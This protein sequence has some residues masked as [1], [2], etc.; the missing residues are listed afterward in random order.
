MGC[1]CLTNAGYGLS[2]ECLFLFAFD[3]YVHELDAHCLDL[4][5]EAGLTSMFTQT[6]ATK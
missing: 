6:T 1:V 4:R 3:P 5:V 2:I